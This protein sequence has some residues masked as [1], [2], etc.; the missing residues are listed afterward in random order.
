MIEEEVKRINQKIQRV[1]AKESE[2]Q[3]KLTRLFYGITLALLIT[4]IYFYITKEWI[5]GGIVTIIALFLLP[6]GK[7]TASQ[8]SSSIMKELQEDK[9]RLLKKLEVIQ[10]QIMESHSSDDE[11]I[12]K[13]LLRDQHV[14]QQIEIETA[15]L[16]Q[17][18]RAYEKVL[19]GF[20]EWEKSGV[21]IE[22]RAVNIKKTYGLPFQISNERLLD[23]FQILEAI[24]DRALNKQKLSE[25][26][27]ELLN[28]VSNFNTKVNTVA[29]QVNFLNEGP[30]KINQIAFR[31]KEEKKKYEQL[32]Q[33]EAKLKDSNEQ[34]S[35]LSF[36]IDY[37]QKECRVLWQIAEVSNEE[38]FRA[39][40]QA[41]ATAK[42][43]L[44]RMNLLNAQLERFGELV[45]NCNLERNYVN[46]IEE[47]SGEITKLNAT[48][49]ERLSQLSAINHRLHELEE[50]GSYADALHT[51]EAGKSI[52]KTM[53]KTGQHLQSRKI[54]YLR[55]LS[56]IVSSDFQK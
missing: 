52:I 17:N 22:E 36:E 42:E 43:L 25:I 18:E 14:R 46:H 23:A 27:E 47:M 45:N 11:D 39:K 31:L 12:T 30:N 34:I 54:S 38:A 41:N 37:L 26:K 8:I 29:K 33:I 15:T 32:L 10:E 5:T 13:K 4:S 9:E 55:Q 19:M 24:K 56:S 20:E 40:G 51:Y 3:A 49:K 44:E 35:K 16:L 48:E 2:N 21:S 28:E 53:Q 7:R 1:K 6:I 50:G